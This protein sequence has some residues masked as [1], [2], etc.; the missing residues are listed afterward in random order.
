MNPV[1][2][3]ALVT[4]G[5]ASWV[6]SLG[7]TIYLLIEVKAMQRATHRIEYINPLTGQNPTVLSEAEKARL[8]EYLE[9]P[10]DNV[11]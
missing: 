11:Q 6:G 3:H 5:V 1:L 7:L 4:F 10:F 9:N 2:E 8:E